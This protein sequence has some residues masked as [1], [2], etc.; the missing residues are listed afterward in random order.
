M[1][2]I[3]IILRIETETVLA[4][5]FWFTGKMPVLQPH[6]NYEL[7]DSTNMILYCS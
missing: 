7:E 2:T 5:N 3:E 6:D 4:V 1:I